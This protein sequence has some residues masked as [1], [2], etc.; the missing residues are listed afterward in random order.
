MT[1]EAP[2]TISVPDAGKRYFGMSRGASYQAADIGPA[3]SPLYPELMDRMEKAGVRMSGA[4]VAWYQ[5]AGDEAVTVHAAFPI[6]GTPPADPGFHVYDLPGLE[7]AATLLHHGHMDLS[8]QSNQTIAAWID[9]NGYRTVGEGYSREVYLDCPP[10]DFDQW[11]TE[12]QVEVSSTSQ[13]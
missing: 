13:V 11:V 7:R 9:E 10:G 3:L 6:V 1:G 8:F 5:S 2:L 4:P 12:L